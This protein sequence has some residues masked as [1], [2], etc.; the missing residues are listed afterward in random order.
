MY[1]INI[2]A[3]NY[4]GTLWWL[5]FLFFVRWLRHIVRYRIIIMVWRRKEKPI[6]PT[7]RR[8][9]LVVEV[10]SLSSSIHSFRIYFHFKHCRRWKFALFFLASSSSNSSISFIRAMRALIFLLLFTRCPRIIFDVSQRDKFFFFLSDTLFYFFALLRDGNSSSIFPYSTYNAPYPGRFLFS[11]PPPH[12]T[13]THF[14]SYS[15]AP[16]ATSKAR[17]ACVEGATTKRRL[18]SCCSVFIAFHI[19]DCSMCMNKI[20]IY[21]HDDFFIFSFTRKEVA[22]ARLAQA[23]RTAGSNSDRRQTTT[24]TT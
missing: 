11:S 3:M 5:L 22:A 15:C 17:K 19:V 6:A 12:K 2:C 7:T 13:H 10:L 20:A 16:S 1:F 9:T 21:I 18:N 8:K 24:G 14:A 4:D 23:R